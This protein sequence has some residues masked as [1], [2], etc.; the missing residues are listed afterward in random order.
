[1]DR[2]DSAA[3]PA[4]SP[5]SDVTPGSPP[6]RGAVPEGARSGGAEGNSRLTGAL[7]A[8]LFI[9]VGL[10]GITLLRVRDL[11]S[12]HVFI[13]M[14]IVP[15]AVLKLGTTGYRFLRYYRGS[16]PYVERGA[17][18]TPLR[19][20]G[21]IVVVTTIALLAT[22]VAA[23]LAGR[24]ARWLV[25]LHKISFFVW[26]GFMAVH[27]LGHILET[28]R[29]ALADWRRARYG[30]ARPGANSRRAALGAA[31]VAGVIL[32]VISLGWVGDWNR[33]GGDR[34]EGASKTPA[35]ALEAPPAARSPAR[36]GG[37]R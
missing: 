27:V 6:H 24:S 34:R 17:P 35:A 12:V 23:V 25:E 18:P 37:R 22:G 36:S 29:L 21:P 19:L 26:I 5:A 14:L 16:R 9:I 1:M 32:G 3:P 15:L 28:P 11:I 13:G 33:D 2:A 31:L 7:G 30:E 4:V 8:A 10:E 20:I